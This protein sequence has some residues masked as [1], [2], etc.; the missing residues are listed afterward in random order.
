LFIS[1]DAK[2]RP[3]HLRLRL[4]IVGLVLT[5]SS[6]GVCYS[7]KKDSCVE[8]HSQMEGELSEPVNRSKE[9]I[10]FG[11]GLSCSNC[12][13]GDPAK[14]DPVSA[15]DKSKGFV[16]RPSPK[17]M[18]NFCGKCHSNADFMK[19]FN[20]GLRVDQQ[21]E[22]L[23]SI[24]GKLLESG[25]ERV[26]TC[27]SCHGVHGIRAVKDAQSMVYPLNVADS[28]AKCHANQEYMKAYSIPHDQ[29]DNYKSSVHAKALYGRQDL[30]APTCNSCHGNHGAAPPGMASVANV[31]GQCH[32]RQSSLF[33]TSVHKAAFD[34]LQVGE[35]KQ[36]HSNHKILP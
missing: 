16:A 11:R 24:H 14:D 17:E 22:Y 32:V 13:G 18:P 5:L 33:Q 7:Q 25:D 20:P 29:Y 12:H 19:K 4:A 23:T 28:C 36:C 10:H 1:C 8:C 2:N 35:C 15:M 9:D 31:C 34:A 21:K 27:I 3:G 30:S 26:A 6:F